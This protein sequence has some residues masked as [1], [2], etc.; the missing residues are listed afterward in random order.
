MFRGTVFLVCEG[1]P[2]SRLNTAHA[3]LL[4]DTEALQADHRALKTQLNSG[5]LEQTRLEAEFSRLKE[6]YQQLDIDSTKLT[7]QCEV[8]ETHQ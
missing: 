4:R 8:Q 1:V 2:V 3:Q 6:Q 5:K 7:N